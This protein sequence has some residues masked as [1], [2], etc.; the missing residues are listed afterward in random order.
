[1]KTI[2]RIIAVLAVTL[3][4]AAALYYFYSASWVTL[5]GF[6]IFWASLILVGLSMSFL[7]YIGL[8]IKIPTSGSYYQPAAIENSGRLYELLGINTYKFILF[9]S[10]FVFLG[11][12][13][14]AKKYKTSQLM[15]L[16]KKMR[17]SEFG[18]LVGFVMV[19][20][21]IIPMYQRSWK[22]AFWLT[23]LNILM[24]LYPIFLQRYNRIRINK[25]GLPFQTDLK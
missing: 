11:K 13:L 14:R 9:H 12:N 25:L 8:F 5:S 23:L 2:L 7:F 10:P 16:E 1:M 15:D 4:H 3:G 24:H 18:H 19:F 6:L 22:F 20:I 21:L 17:I